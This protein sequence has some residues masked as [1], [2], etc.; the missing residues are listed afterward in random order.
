MTSES[1]N[2]CGIDEN[3]DAPN[4]DTGYGGYLVD[5]LALDALAE[6]GNV[7]AAVNYNMKFDRYGGVIVKSDIYALAHGFALEKV[8][9]TVRYGTHSHTFNTEAACGNITDEV[10][11]NFG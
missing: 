2:A 4:L 3:I 10:G 6:Y 9:E 1:V 11:E 7:D 8:V 5:D